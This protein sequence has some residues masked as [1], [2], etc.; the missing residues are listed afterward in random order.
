MGS[1]N[2]VEERYFVD[3]NS[4]EYRAGYLNGFCDGYEEGKKMGYQI[5]YAKGRLAEKIEIFDTFP[6]LKLRR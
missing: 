4:M 5:G 3:H 6:E 2:N 1:L